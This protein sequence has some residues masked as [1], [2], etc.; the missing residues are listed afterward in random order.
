MLYTDPRGVRGGIALIFFRKSFF[1]KHPNGEPTKMIVMM[2]ANGDLG[3]F[4]VFDYYKETSTSGFFYSFPQ[5]K[6]C[7]F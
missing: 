5:R 1:E 7:R 2:L 4:V 6:N 3:P